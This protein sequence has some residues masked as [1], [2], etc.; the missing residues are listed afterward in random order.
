VTP[1][2]NAEDAEVAENAEM[3]K[4]RRTEREGW[5]SPTVSALSANLRDLDVERAALRETR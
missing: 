5:T 4:E 3:R 1:R 2:I